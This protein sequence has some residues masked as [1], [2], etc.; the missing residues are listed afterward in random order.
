MAKTSAMIGPGS[1]LE[2]GTQYRMPS[3]TPVRN[4]TPGQEQPGKGNEEEEARNDGQRE[5]AAAAASITPGPERDAG[6]NVRLRLPAAPLP[7]ANDPSVAALAHPQSWALT[8]PRLAE[9]MPSIRRS[10]PVR[11]GSRPPAGSRISCSI[12]AASTTEISP[13]GTLT[14]NTQ[15]QLT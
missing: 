15:R 13:R 5:T 7:G 10:V 4:S 14:M 12:R 6:L 1:E 9:A 8:R 2:A 3:H 11:S